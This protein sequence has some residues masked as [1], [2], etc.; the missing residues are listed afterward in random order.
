MKIT[1]E[2]LIQLIKEELAELQEQRIDREAEADADVRQSIKRGIG[3]AGKSLAGKLASYDPRT[4]QKKRA[5]GYKSMADKKLDDPRARMRAKE[6]RLKMGISAT[7]ANMPD[8]DQKKW[9]ADYGDLPIRQQAYKLGL[10]E[11]RVPNADMLEEII[12][13]EFEAALSENRAFEAAK[14]TYA[15]KLAALE[16]AETAEQKRK[17]LKAIKDLERRYPQLKR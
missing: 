16:K 13:E 8:A 6:D 15:R 11:N 17:L 4:A 10:L 1:K 3:R 7:L 14:K 12:F 9:L 2:T 5:A